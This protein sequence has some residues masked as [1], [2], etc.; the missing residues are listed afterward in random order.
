MHTR[1]VAVF[2][3]TSFALA[4]TVQ[5]Q[6][7][8]FRTDAAN[9]AFTWYWDASNTIFRSQSLCAIA[10]APR[11]SNCGVSGLTATGASSATLGG[12]LNVASS[13]RLNSVAS[14]IA[15]P[16]N[17]YNWGYS[18]NAYASEYDRL[19]FTG[20][21]PWI[22]QPLE[23]CISIFWRHTGCHPTVF[24]DGGRRVWRCRS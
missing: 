24:S 1:T 18:S 20:V 13:L 7:A 9:Y 14:V 23:Q 19:E 15:L 8:S 21:T 5:S 4:T 2:A 16:A 10:T 11:A 22:E 12:S 6:P 17:V 3:F